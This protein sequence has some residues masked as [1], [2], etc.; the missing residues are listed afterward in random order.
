MS[1]QTVKLSDETT[2]IL[3]LYVRKRGVNNSSAIA[4]MVSDSLD[5]WVR[6]QNKLDNHTI[7]NATNAPVSGSID[8]FR[9]HLFSQ[10]LS[11]IAINISRELNLEQTAEDIGKLFIKTIDTVIPDEF[12]E[13]QTA[14]FR[15]IFAKYLSDSEYFKNWYQNFAMLFPVVRA[16]FDSELLVN[17]YPI[18]NDQNDN[19]A[20]SLEDEEIVGILI[21]N[22][23]RKFPLKLSNQNIDQIKK[24]LDQNKD[25]LIII[26]GLTG[27][28]KTTLMV[29]LAQRTHA[30]FNPIEVRSFDRDFEKPNLS[31]ISTM[32]AED[33]GTA[34]NRL[35]E[36]ATFFK[37]KPENLKKGT[38]ILFIHTKIRKDT[39]AKTYPRYVSEI[40][41]AVY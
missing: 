30:V 22:Y 38:S 35:H 36:L 28:G 10:E 20:F 40:K 23:W 19:S 24:F 15:K 5:E 16:T 31:K 33:N 4:S 37:A 27:S 13:K 18:F 21:N 6:T 12:E 26:N 11:A 32:H 25:G 1:R 2:K 34:L 41:E 9:S 39:E 3:E 29:E 14:H 17:G 8:D 7:S